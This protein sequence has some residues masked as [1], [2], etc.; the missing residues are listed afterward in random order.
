M[1]P[2]FLTLAN[3][4]T[5]IAYQA[6]M[7]EQLEALRERDIT[8]CVEMAF[9]SGRPTNLVGI[10]P[11]ELTKREIDL[12]TRLLREADPARGLKPTEQAVRKVAQRAAAGMTQEQL[13]VFTDETARLRTPPVITCNAAINFFAGLNRIPVAERGRALR[14]LY[15]R[16]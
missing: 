10:L 3:D 14:V 16:S 5:L 8:A 6:L 15:S 13:L 12:M 1:L 4:E 11:P 7:Q 2:K 9:P